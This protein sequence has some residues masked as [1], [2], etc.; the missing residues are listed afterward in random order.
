[1]TAAYFKDCIDYDQ[2]CQLLSCD[3]RK[4]PLLSWR[5]D[6]AIW[7]WCRQHTL[8]DEDS[9]EAWAKSLCSRK[10]VKMFLIG[11]LGEYV[12]VCGLTDI[13]HLNQRAE[14]SLYIAPEFQGRGLAKSALKTLLCHG[15]LDLNLNCIWG[16]SFENNPAQ[17]LFQK[18]GFKFEGR[19]RHFYYRE[20]RFIDACL[21]SA[22]RS[23]WVSNWPKL[24]TKKI[25]SNVGKLIQNTQSEHLKA[26]AS[27]VG[28]I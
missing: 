16:E 25:H 6:P 26:H 9:H 2:G 4:A 13:D 24:P 19:R 28:K 11:N 3:P 5:N 21:Y 17:N 23:D 12:G 8:I 15:F 7:Q 27:P 14:F 20:G 22:L 18:V 1:M 10:D